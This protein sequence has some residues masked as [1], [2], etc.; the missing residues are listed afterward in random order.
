MSSCVFLGDGGRTG[1]AARCTVA[2]FEEVSKMEVLDVHVDEAG[3]ASAMLAG[4]LMPYIDVG[5]TPYNYHPTDD[6]VAA[7]AAK[8]ASE[9]VRPFE[10]DCHCFGYSD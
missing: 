3:S 9:Q 6:E 5:G 4:L 8:A 10:C 1:T 7:A 2:F